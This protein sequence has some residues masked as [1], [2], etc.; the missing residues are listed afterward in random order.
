MLVLAILVLQVMVQME[1]M[2]EDY[3]GVLEEYF[4]LHSEV[5]VIPCFLLEV[6]ELYVLNK[7]SL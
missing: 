6:F 4:E 5:L 2:G 1:E 7:D 3:S